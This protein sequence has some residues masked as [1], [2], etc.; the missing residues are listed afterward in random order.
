M[1]RQKYIITVEGFAPVRLEFE[2]WADDEHQA[3]KQLDNPGL[4]NIRQRPD[5]DISRLK[6][7]KVSIKEAFTSVIKLINSY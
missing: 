7:K 4:V 2:T 6:R 5:V 1:A 3:L